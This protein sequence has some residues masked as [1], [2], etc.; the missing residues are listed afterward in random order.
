M[1]DVAQQGG[2]IEGVVV[3]MVVD[4]FTH[5]AFDFIAEIGFREEQCNSFLVEAVMGSSKCIFVLLPQD[6]GLGCVPFTAVGVTWLACG[7]SPRSVAHFLEAMC[8]LD[9]TASVCAHVFGVGHE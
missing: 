6:D 3:I 9:A 4:V 8:L 2:K 7:F 5:Q 1:V